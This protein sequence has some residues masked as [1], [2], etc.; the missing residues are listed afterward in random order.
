MTAGATLVAW[1][2][3]ERPAITAFC[4]L[5]LACAVWAAAGAA[6]MVAPDAAVAELLAARVRMVAVA[7]TPLFFLIFC[8]QYAGFRLTPLRVGLLSVIP[9]V[10]QILNCTPLHRLLIAGVTFVRVGP[11]FIGRQPVTGP[12]F[13][14]HA[15]YSF[16]LVAAGLALLLRQII[17]SRDF[18]R[19]QAAILFGGLLAAVAASATAN[20]ALARHAS[21]DLRLDWTIPSFTLIGLTWSWALLRVRFLDVM[22]VALDAVFRCMAEAVIVL[23]DDGRIVDVNPAAATLIGQTRSALIGTQLSAELSGDAPEVTVGENVLERQVSPLVTANAKVIVLRDITER[24]RLVR[25][26]DA[27][28]RTV[29]HDLKNPLSAVTVFSDLILRSATLDDDTRRRLETIAMAG[30]NMT[31]IINALLLFARVRSARE[32]ETTELD[33]HVIVSNV[34]QRLAPQI[35]RAAARIDVASRWPAARGYAPWVEE[36]W[37]NY[38]SNALKYGGNPPRIE[39]GGDETGPRFWVRDHGPGLDEPA[40]QRLFR[41]FERLD[42]APTTPGHGLGLSIV[43]RIASKLGGRAGVES[44]KGEGCTFWFTLPGGAYNDR[45]P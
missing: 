20:L 37:A 31:E 12:W 24:A 8:L 21:G 6:A 28:A 32:V 10:T 11:F 14:I 27:Y 3:R 33:M 13:A 45:L 5:M 7:L 16:L 39:L 38:I 29:A 26:L 1:H 17:R 18:Y 36:L 4:W 42:P 9:A 40:R 22:P 35:E 19:T 44:A 43:S 15:I 25:D 30:R 41:E 2:R 34:L 23:D